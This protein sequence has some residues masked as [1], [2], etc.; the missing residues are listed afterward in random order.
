MQWTPYAIPFRR[1]LVTSHGRWDARDGIIVEIETDAGLRGLGD[2]APL[3]EFGTAGVDACLRALEQIAPRLVGSEIGDAACAFDAAFPDAS[4]APLRCAIESACLDVDAGTTVASML[5][6]A[7]AVAVA[8]NA[9]VADAREAAAAVAAGYRCIKLK[10]G[11]ATPAEDI[12][13]VA[14]VRGAVGPAVALRLDANGAWSEHEA[15]AVLDGVAPN[16]I[17][18]VEQPVAAGDLEALRRIRQSTR[19]PLAADEAI[20]SVKAARRILDAGAAD[21][22][23]VKPAVIGGPRRAM[24]IV[25]MARAGGVECVVTSA[26]ESGIGVAAALHVAAASRPLHACGLAT[27]ELL[28]DDLVSG[29]LRVVDG[30]MAVPLRT[31]LGIAL[32]P[33]ALDRYRA[34]P[35]CTRVR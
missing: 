28:A 23:I 13:R 16:G 35:T 14:A 3:P 2:V 10:V 33:L 31:G 26:M 34:G 30:M 12:A 11:T 8:V 25:E 22:L 18:F 32:Q 6:D 21:V 29:R 1:A 20:T 4:L 17:E 19:M 5:A 27:L 24:E 7:P 15:I 9:I